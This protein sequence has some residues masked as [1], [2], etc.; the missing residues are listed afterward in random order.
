MIYDRASLAEDRLSGVK[1]IAVFI[2][3]S[4][5]RTSYLLEARRL[6]AGKLGAKWVAS[7][8]RIT[9]FYATLTAGKA[10]G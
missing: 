10:A 2:G 4:E 5:R 3:E 6:P 9:E 7:K 8:R 1:E